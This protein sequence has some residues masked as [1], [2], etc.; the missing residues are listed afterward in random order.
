MIKIDYKNREDIIK[1]YSHRLLDDMDFDSLYVFAYE[2]LVESKGK[3]NNTN[4]EN[5]IKNLYPEIL[6]D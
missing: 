4:L 3:L 5:E 6:G 2:T 1:S